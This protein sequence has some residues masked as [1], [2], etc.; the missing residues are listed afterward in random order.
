MSRESSMNVALP[1]VKT[2]ATNA[3]LP[4]VQSVRVCLIDDDDDLRMLLRAA[5]EQG[6]CVVDKAANGAQAMQQLAESEPPEV[7]IC[8][9]RMPDRDGSTLLPPIRE[10]YPTVPAILISSYTEGGSASG[11]TGHALKQRLPMPFAP[12]VLLA[13]VHDIALRNPPQGKTAGLQ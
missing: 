12:E 13:H 2:V 11:P 8:D 5:L 9:H 4:G 3:P 1:R 10:R 6:G 7:L